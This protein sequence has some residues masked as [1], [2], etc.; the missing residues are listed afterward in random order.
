VIK[1]QLY[2]SPSIFLHIRHDDLDEIVHHQSY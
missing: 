2:F 1:Q